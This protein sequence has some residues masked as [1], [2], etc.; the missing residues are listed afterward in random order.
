MRD[1]INSKTKKGNKN[2]TALITAL[3]ALSKRGTTLK[4][5]FL[6]ANFVKTRILQSRRYL[7]METANAPIQSASSQ[8]HVQNESTV[9]RQ[10]A[11]GT[12]NLT[13]AGESLYIL[14]V[15]R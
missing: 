6:A 1:F 14:I 3:E 4:E 9:S 7:D 8:H 2:Y 13:E 15:Y 5:D 10:K 11:A 12:E